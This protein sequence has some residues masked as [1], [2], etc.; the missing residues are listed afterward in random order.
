MDRYARTRLFRIYEGLNGQPAF[1]FVMGGVRAVQQ[2]RWTRCDGGQLDYLLEVE[3]MPY[4]SVGII[5]LGQRRSLFPGEAFYLYDETLLRQEYWSASLQ[6]SRPETISH[7]VRVFDALREQ[8]VFG[9]DAPHPVRADD[10]S[11][12]VAV[13]VKQGKSD[14]SRHARHRE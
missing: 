7:F 12:T 4:V 10:H 5:P 8:A 3:Q 9:A 13:S 6:T 2:R 11:R 1:V 14:H